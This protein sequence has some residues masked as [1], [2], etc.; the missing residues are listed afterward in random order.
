MTA[1]RYLDLLA[2]A[3]TRDLCLAEAVRTVDLREWPDGEPEGL[4][5]LLSERQWRV[6]R[7]GAASCPAYTR[8]APT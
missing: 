8:S 4:R 2:R 6:V 3:L 5:A 7:P 1:E